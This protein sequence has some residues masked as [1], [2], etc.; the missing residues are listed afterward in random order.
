V[1]A[2]TKPPIKWG[3]HGAPNQFPEAEMKAPVPES[4][5]MNSE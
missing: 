5:E 1:E 2:V 4:R 3:S